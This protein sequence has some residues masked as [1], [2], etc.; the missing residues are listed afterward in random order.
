M[1]GEVKK[2]EGD[3]RWLAGVLVRC[4]ALWMTYQESMHRIG[5][6][7]TRDV[8]AVDRAAKY[9]HFLLG[10]SSSPSSDK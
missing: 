7:D 9:A 10:D 6:L 4:Y 8:T 5:D 1:E 3:W 2:T